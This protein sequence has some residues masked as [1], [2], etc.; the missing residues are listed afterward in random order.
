[1]PVD[2][3]S[4]LLEAAVYD[5]SQAILELSFRSGIS[6]RYW[7]VPAQVYHR[8]LQAESKGKFY[9]VHIRNRYLHQDAR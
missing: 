7:N 6:Y 1:M 8:L 5:R 3:S 9:N 2:W 4:R